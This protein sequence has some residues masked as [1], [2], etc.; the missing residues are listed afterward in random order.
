MAAS[1]CPVE[2]AVVRDQQPSAL[3]SSASSL[4]A[5]RSSRRWSPSD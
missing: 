4:L 2:T 1:T 3:P 5:P